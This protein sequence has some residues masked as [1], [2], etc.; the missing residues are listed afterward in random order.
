MNCVPFL[1]I[2]DISIAKKGE[3][4]HIST[5]PNTNAAA[6]QKPTLDKLLDRADRQTCIQHQI[7]IKTA[8]VSV[9]SNRYRTNHPA[10]PKAAV[11]MQ[12]W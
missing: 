11:T 10:L 4:K 9:N 12:A 8:H 5:I 7:R 6:I 1:Y 2:Y 3:T